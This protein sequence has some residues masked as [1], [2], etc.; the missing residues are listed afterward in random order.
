MTLYFARTLALPG[1]L[2]ALASSASAQARPPIRQLGAV[3]A[4]TTDSLGMV[5]NVRALPG[6]RLLVNDATSRRVLLVDSAFK[7]ISIVADSTSSTAN[8]YGPRSGSLIAYRGDSTLFV[9]AASLSMLVI[10]PA[11]KIGRV[12]SVP[13]S[14]DAMM[15]AAGGLGTGAYY[16][17]GYLVYRGMPGFRM[18]MGPSGTPTMPSVA[19]TMAIVRVNLQSRAVDTVG[20]IKIPKTNTN[21]TRSDDGKISISIEVNPL[22]VVDDWVVTSSGDIALLRGKDYHVD[23]MSP[24]GTHRSSPKMAFDWKRLTD[25]QKVALIDSVKAIR[26]RAAAANPGQGNAMAAAFGAALG[27]GGGAG[28]AAPQMVMRF[29]SRG[30]GGPP[31]GGAAPQIMAPQINYVSPSEL[32][33]YQPAFFAT[34]AKAD[35]DGNIWVR[36]IPTK[37]TP[38]GAV[39]DVVNAKGE[40][41]DR[42][43]IPENRTIVGF[44]AGGVVILAVREGMTTKLERARV[45]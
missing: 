42:V 10:D 41:V 9:D 21:M 11:G 1:L 17:N 14:Q 8:A 33:D 7:L 43:Q 28:G 22:P 12:M 16:S 2:T 30:P 13:R 40:V 5:N 26:D 3:H 36:T 39:Y 25:E 27:T 37:P 18:Q 32:P 15:L 44:G 23:W 35:D 24:D 20:F 4:T 6:G 38:G 19:D 31:G 45:K 34:S 29:E